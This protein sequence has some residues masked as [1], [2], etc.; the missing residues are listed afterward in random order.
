ML[1][2]LG[3]AGRP[4][5]S[6]LGP[7]SRGEFH[8]KFRR[9]PLPVQVARP[10]SLP[11]DE[12]RRTAPSLWERERFI[13]VLESADGREVAAVQ[14]DQVIQPFV[15]T[16]A[17]QVTFV[18][19]SVQHVS[20]IPLLRI[21]LK[22]ERG[23]PSSHKLQSS[24]RHLPS[25]SKHDP[26]RNITEKHGPKFLRASKGQVPPETRSRTSL[27]PLCVTHAYLVAFLDRAG[28]SV[29]Y[30]TVPPRAHP[31]TGL[32][33]GSATPG[34]TQVPSTRSRGLLIV[35]SEVSLSQGTIVPCVFVCDCGVW[36]H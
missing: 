27:C 31:S 26:P 11:F 15:N 25:S 36:S 6:V 22:I 19:F 24:V 30:F 17:G 20:E 35:A 28:Q 4:I 10:R 18:P 1:R 29:S 23:N 21:T 34:L 13:L 3:G 16:S 32:Q 7:P 14:A 12:P 8:Y 5:P 9:V 2:A 33:S